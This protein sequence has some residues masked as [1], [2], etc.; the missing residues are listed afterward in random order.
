MEGIDIWWSESLGSGGGGSCVRSLVD[1]G[2][3]I[4]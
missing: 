1:V 2:N 4:V 3:R